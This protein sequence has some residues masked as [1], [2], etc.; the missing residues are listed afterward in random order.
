MLG[1]HRRRVARLSLLV[2]HRVQILIHA[3][4]RAADE[5]VRMHVQLSG[6][7]RVHVRGLVRVLV[8]HGR[9]LHA[10]LAGQHIVRPV[11]VPTV[12]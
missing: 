8:V 7:A 5:R 4:R 2:L 9:H 10:R 1:R 3:H 11:R 6:L 12:D